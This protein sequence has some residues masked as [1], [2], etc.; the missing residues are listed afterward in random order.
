MGQG[1]MT[2]R[3][4]VSAPSGGVI[5]SIQQ[6]IVPLTGTTTN[7][8]MSSVDPSKTMITVSQK[9]TSSSAAYLGHAVLTSATNVAFYTRLDPTSIVTAYITVIEYESGVS[10]QR[11][12]S[13]FSALSLNVNISSVDVTKSFIN[14]LG[15]G[16][17]TATNTQVQHM[18][19]GG[20]I[21]SPTQITLSK[22]TTT[23]QTYQS[24]EVV[25]FL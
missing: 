21:I 4:S 14:I 19:S 18:L 3:G 16:V 1:I 2:R 7:I 25:T 13:L 8:P 17:G 10:V 12:R 23:V 20:T 15:V 22:G 5:K 11:G 9:S 6:F 24:W